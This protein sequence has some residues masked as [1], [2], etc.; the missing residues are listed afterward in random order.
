MNRNI[1]SLICGLVMTTVTFT[2]CDY[3]DIV[4]VEQPSLDDAYSRPEQTLGFLYSCYSGL[5]KWNPADYQNEDVSSTDEYVLPVAGNW[6]LNSYD[7]QTNQRSSATGG[8]WHWRYCGYDCIHQC[9]LFMNIVDNAPGLTNEQRTVWEAKALVAYYHFMI[10]RKY[11]PCPIMDRA[12]DED[13]ETS[14]MPGRSHYDHVTKYIV[15]L[16]DEAMPDLPDRWTDGNWGRIDKVVAKA[17]K[18]RV[19]LYA[20]SP[21]WNGNS[22]YE[23]GKL[24]WKNET[25]TDGDYGRQLVN[26]VYD[27]KKW[28]VAKDACEEALTFALGHGLKLYEETKFDEL[29]DADSPDSEFMM[30]VLRMRYAL[31]SRPNAIGKCQE[32]VW[33]TAN[34]SNIVMASLPRRMYVQ[35][36]GLWK[37]GWSGVAPTL[38]AVEKFYTKNGKPIDKDPEFPAKSDWFKLA[39]KAVVDKEPCYN[40]NNL[41]EDKIINLNT[42]REPRF[43]AW[44]GY[45]GGEFGIKLINGTSMTL[46]FMD[47]DLQGYNPNISARDYCK[48]GFLCQKWIHPSLT[49]T[50][51]GGSNEGTYSSQ[52]PLI[53]MAELYLNLAECYAALDDNANFLKNINPVRKRAGIPEL[54]ESDLTSDMTATDWV[55]NERFI[56]FYGEGIRFYD[57]RRWM[58]GKEAY[59]HKFY[60]MNM[61]QY[62]GPTF[63]QYNTPKVISEY[64]DVDW[65]DRMYIMPLY[66]EEVDKTKNLIQAPGY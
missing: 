15:D 9:F 18:A 47:K 16:L 34:Q 25:W 17:I 35:T 56:E 66:F 42:R 23:S 52:R 14:D 64:E 57:L 50:S 41:K 10:L 4:P 43:Y 53:R 63:E 11:G 28:E 32:V 21:L 46:D 54:K 5:N 61:N 27:R 44:M 26:P 51:N 29:E 45:D 55:R 49:F 31:L 62:I 65:N 36:D 7:I 58:I 8:D 3:L 33:G 13:T 59:G 38:N 30:Y 37:D 1:Y 48:T 6:C 2:A 22:L 19:L 20:A 12:Y 39:G 40:R 60:G 24:E